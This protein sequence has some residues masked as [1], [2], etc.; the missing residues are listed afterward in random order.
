MSGVG[1]V[2][3]TWMKL[4]VQITT[5]TITIINPIIPNHNLGHATC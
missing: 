3:K 5:A 4:S 1:I 2:L